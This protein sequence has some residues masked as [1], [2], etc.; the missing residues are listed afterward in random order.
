MR[1]LLP[2]FAL[3]MVSLLTEAQIRIDSSFAF[4]TNPAKGYSIY[5][6]SSY[7]SSSPN[8]LMVSFHPLNLLRWDA[9]SWC[10]TLQAFSEANDLVMICPDG[11]SNGNI[12]DSIDYAF[13]TVL[14]DSMRNWYSIDDNRIYAI[15]FSM[16]GKAVYEYGL[17]NASMFGGFIP[18]GP[19]I[20]GS[21]FVSGV[22]QNAGGRPFHLVHG[23]SDM[24]TFSFF[25]MLSA[26]RNNCALVDST[27][28]AGVGHT[29]DFPNRNAILGA[30]FRWVDSVNLAPRSGTFSLASPVN[31]S[32]ITTKG[33][34]SYEH[35]FVWGQNSIADSCGVMKYELLVDLPSGNFTNPILILPSD[36]AGSDTVLTLTNEVID[37]LL[38]SYNIPLNGSLAL[39]WTVRSNTLNKY[40]DT[41]K[42]FRIT[43]TRKALGFGLTTPSNN[44]VVTLQNS[45]TKY[46]N[47]ED[48]NH[49]I[50]VKYHLLFDDTAAN[51]SVP[52]HEYLSS[53]N[54]TSSS[55]NIPHEQLYYDMFFASGAGIGDSVTVKWN[56]LAYDTAISELSDNERIITFIRGQV[57][58]DLFTISN[59]S[60]I[61]SKKDVSYNFSWDSVLLDNVRY[62]W[63]FDTLGSDLRTDSALFIVPSSNDSMNARVTIGFDIL[64]SMMNHYGVPYFDTLDGQWTVRAYRDTVMEYALTIRNVSIVRNRPVGIET[65]NGSQGVN[66]YPNPS[67]GIIFVEHPGE[68]VLRIFGTDSKLL[69]EVNL[70]SEGTILEMDLSDWPS[71]NYIWTITDADGQKSGKIVLQRD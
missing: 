30:A 27:Y 18:I 4:G 39:D 59:N 71:G 47:W 8:A 28:M 60:L 3:L 7:S 9:E 67:K 46:F 41:A 61:T 63:I 52:L 56:A 40:A 23:S 26:L 19:A 33:F 12:T 35:H 54:G 36:N 48:L 43:F 14:I 34:R 11:G 15:G 57:G 20:N 2:F 21:T 16:G 51:F 64:D 62:E 69:K 24:P 49:Y 29:I 50:G 1:R 66:V 25:P 13:T 70:S 53:N 65:L 68:G 58:F 42:S 17:N 45:S 55:L 10:D 44:N 32:T 31:L 6:P 37:S 22:L 5:V 38:I